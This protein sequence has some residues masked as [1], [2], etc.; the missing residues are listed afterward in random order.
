MSAGD[1][2]REY[3]AAPEIC[4]EDLHNHVQRIARRNDD[5]LRVY[6]RLHP[7]RGDK[8]TFSVGVKETTDGHELCEEF[9]TTITEA[10]NTLRMKGLKEACEEWEYEYVE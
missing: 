7:Q 9:A 1:E 6:V 10:C 4:L 3:R 5:P 2:L 8:I